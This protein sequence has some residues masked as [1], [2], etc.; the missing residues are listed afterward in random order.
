MAHYRIHHASHY[1]FDAAVTV[2]DCRVLLQPRDTPQQRCEDTSVFTLPPA[3]GRSH[4]RDRFENLVSNFS[5]RSP[6]TSFEIKAVSRICTRPATGDTKLALD[7]PLGKL[8]RGGACAPHDLFLQ[9]SP[10]VSAG[11]TLR[12]YAQI[13][14][15]G[16]QTVG[17][18]LFDLMTRLRRDLRYDCQASDPSARDAEAL[19]R[20]AGVCQ[21]FAHVMIGCLRALGL[22]ARYVGGYM[23]PAAKR[24]GSAQQQP[25]AWCAVLLPGGI[26]TDIDPTRGQLCGPD[27]I[28]VAWGRDYCDVSPVHGV[29]DGGQLTESRVSIEI[30]REP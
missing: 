26:W 20:R 1:R 9:A 11:P 21:D 25:H 7:E 15:G 13:S 19:Q 6:T 18:A 29:F 16:D 4:A 14:F 22:P 3:A 10:L 12:D 27:H 8:L 23:A 24:S 28:T 30:S 5:L 2:S 17:T